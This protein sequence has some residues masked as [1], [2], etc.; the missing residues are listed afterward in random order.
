MSRA[1][2]VLILVMSVLAIGAA[3]ALA[4][5]S[6]PPYT[7]TFTPPTGGNVQGAGI[8]CGAGGT[9]CSVTMPAAMTLGLQAT[10]SAGYTFTMWTGD[11]TGTTAGL[12]LALGGPRSCGVMFTPVGG[13]P[14]TPVITWSTPAPITQG[15]ALSAAQLNATTSVAGSFVYS[16]GAG[17]VL[18]AGSYTLSTTFTPTNTTLYTGA[19]KTVTQVVNAPAGLTTPVITWPTPAPITQGT[20]LSAAQLNATTTV[21][22]SFV[23]TPGAGTVLPAGSYTLSTTFTPTNTTLY[24]SASKTVTQVVNASGATTAGAFTVYDASNVVVGPLIS[25]ST[26]ALSVGGQRYVAS[27]GPDGWLQSAV[28]L[29]FFDAACGGG[30]YSLRTWSATGPPATPDPMPGYFFRSLSTVGS[31][32]YYITGQYVSR[33][34]SVDVPTVWYRDGVSGPCTPLG[35]AGTAWFDEVGVVQLPAHQPPFTIR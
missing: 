26:V 4:Q 22:G 12:W 17:T 11:C 18:P 1:V 15:T 32:G 9:A 2:R 13:A 6:G 33:A 27:A 20:A 19:S 25:S 8:N 23:Y 10:A 24:T 30:L 31:T 5:T 28:T 34:L 7:L 14:T 3:P 16:P 29:Y 35:L 21:A